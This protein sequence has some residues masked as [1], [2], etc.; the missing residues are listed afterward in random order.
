MSSVVYC[1][2][3]AVVAGIYRSVTIHKAVYCSLN[4]A[5]SLLDVDTQDKRP[6]ECYAAHVINVRPSVCRTATTGRKT[7]TPDIVCRQDKLNKPEIWLRRVDLLTLSSSGS[8]TAA[9]AA[10]AAAGDGVGSTYV[11]A[12]VGL[13]FWKRDVNLSEKP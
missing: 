6:P 2:R 3:A 5:I 10:A 11:I 9:A 7:V 13:S 12:H 1:G 8:P 4:R